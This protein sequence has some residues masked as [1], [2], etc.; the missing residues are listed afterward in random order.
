M[1]R[2][3]ITEIEDY[4]A[5]GC[6]RCARFATSNCSTRRWTAGLVELRRLCREAGLTEAVKWGHPCYMHAGCNIAIIGA[7]RD[8]FR[9]SFFNAAL[10]HDPQGVLERQ[11]PNARIPDMFRFTDSAQAAAMAETITA[12]LKEAMGYAEAGLRPPKDHSEIDLPDELLDALGADLEL[13][14]AFHQLSPG[15][16]KS[17]VINLSSAKTSATRIARITKFRPKILAGKGANEQ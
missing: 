13:A 9:L 2:V 15:R 8:D 10:M 14:E 1:R 16:R 3:I 5:K 4:F 6:G 7:L 11:G 12:Y 17:Y